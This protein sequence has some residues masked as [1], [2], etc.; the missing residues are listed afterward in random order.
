[1]RAIV[2]RLHS[3]CACFISI[4]GSDRAIPLQGGADGLSVVVFI[5]GCA[6]VGVDV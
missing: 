3:S 1:M 4:D 5:V 2:E 6:P